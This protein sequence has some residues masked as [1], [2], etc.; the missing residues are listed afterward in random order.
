MATYGSVYIF[1]LYPDTASLTDL[2]GQGGVGSIAA[3]TK[4]SSAP[5]YA[6]QQVSVTRTNITLDELNGPAFVNAGRGGSPEVNTLSVNYGGQAWQ[7]KVQ[8]PNPP[9]P[10]LEADLWLYLAYQQAFLFNATDGQLIPGPS[11]AGFEMVEV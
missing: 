4:G 7:A 1:N 10:Q 9:D 5:Y 2:N 8:I 3:P 6:P 11:G